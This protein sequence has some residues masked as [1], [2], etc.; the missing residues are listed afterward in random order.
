M[1]HKSTQGP[2]SRSSR[3]EY[4][5]ANRLVE[6][7]NDVDHLEVIQ[8]ILAVCSALPAENREELI[9][10]KIMPVVKELPSDVS[11][12]VK[13]ALAEVITGMGPLLGEPNT[14]T[15]L[16]PLFLTLLRDDT[17]E[18]RLNIISSLDKVR[19]YSSDAS[20]SKF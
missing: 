12:H 2:R 7:Y 20:R 3:C 1:V 11:H 15:H 10:E 5:K 19:V 14:R 18:A 4:E 17:P 16:L 13:I 9:V 6:F 8:T